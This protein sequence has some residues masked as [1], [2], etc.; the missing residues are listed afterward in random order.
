MSEIE[1]T[2]ANKKYDAVFLDAGYTLFSATPSPPK[3][4]HQVC[5][6]H[7]QHIML[8]QMIQAMREVWVEY[9]IPEMNDP[10][11]TFVC[12]NDEDREWW[13]KYDQQVFT[14]LGIT[15]ARQREIFDEIYC[16]FAN[17]EAWQLYPD[18]LESL[19]KLKAA[20][21]SLGIVSNWNSSLKKIVEG[22]NLAQYFDF[23]LSSA[24]AG[25][26]KP[27]AKIFEMALKLT[28]LE[29]SRV[30]H[31]GDTYQTDVLGARNAG[32]RGI[33]LDRRGSLQRHDH[34]V[35]QGLAELYPLLIV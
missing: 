19:D 9:V 11:S 7:G 34:E 30:I 23:I 33:M 22:L 13:W 25:W 3:F 4:Y 27:S 5:V 17:A 28:G 21:F 32:I 16:F 20:S 24:E 26:K 29:R 6:R 31:I 14:K 18:T 15:P 1:R 10:A 8:D 35:I 2:M 12:S